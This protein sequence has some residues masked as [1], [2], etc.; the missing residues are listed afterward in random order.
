MRLLFTTL[1]ISLA[2]LPLQSFAITD[3]DVAEVTERLES[4]TTDELVNR[5]TE[6]ENSLE[7]GDLNE[8]DRV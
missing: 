6:L 7:E 4:L 3:S 8:E 1:A 5:K 2:F